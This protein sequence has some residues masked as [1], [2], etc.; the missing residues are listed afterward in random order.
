MDCA[1]KSASRF[2][3]TRGKS[4]PLFPVCS[5]R[6]IRTL[7]RDG[8]SQATQAFPRP[9]LLQTT[10]TLLHAWALLTHPVSVKEPWARSL[11]DLEKPAFERPLVFITQQL[12]T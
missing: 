2:M 1:G 12:R 9:W 11:A 7:P 5:P 6:S 4:R 3:I 8:S 10:R